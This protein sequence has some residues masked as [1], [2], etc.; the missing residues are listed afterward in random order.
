[1]SQLTGE[2]RAQ[3]RVLLADIREVSLA[4]LDADGTPFASFV[5]TAPALDGRPLLLLSDLAR[6]TKNLK[7]QPQCS[8]LFVGKGN[9]QADPLVRCRVTLTGRLARAADQDAAR[10]R[11]CAVNKS[12]A[13]Y[14]GFGDFSL[15]RMA[16]SGGHLVA[17]FGRIAELSVDDL[18]ADTHDN[19]STGAT[20]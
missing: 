1:M 17:G 6:H 4:T 5:T 8:M 15:Y 10:V 13:D 9:D 20:P 16:V 7:R 14:S 2:L 11:F 18:F 19:T 12:A 3:V